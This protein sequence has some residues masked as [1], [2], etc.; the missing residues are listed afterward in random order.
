M[1]LVKRYLVHA[2]NQ[3]M[4]INSN[5]VK[6]AIIHA[7]EDKHLIKV[8]KSDKDIPFDNKSFKKLFNRMYKYAEDFLEQLYTSK[9]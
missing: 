7:L 4:D 3:E 2:H 9:G 1:L 8:F 6:Q 5:L